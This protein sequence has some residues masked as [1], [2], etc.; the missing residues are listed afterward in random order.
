VVQ[1][2]RVGGRAIG[3]IPQA[4]A[5]IAISSTLS[6]VS[7]PCSQSSSTQSKPAA[8]SEGRLDRPGRSGVECGHIK[9]HSFKRAL[10][11]RQGD[12]DAVPEEQLE[13]PAP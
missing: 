2:L 9:I 5:A 11:G 8:A 1:A 6:S 4:S 7:V 3:V 10:R 12:D 13:P